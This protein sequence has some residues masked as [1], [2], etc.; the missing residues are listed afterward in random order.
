MHHLELRPRDDIDNR[1]GRCKKYYE[2]DRKSETCNLQIKRAPHLQHR[3]ILPTSEAARKFRQLRSAGARRFVERLNR[4]GFS[5]ARNA[6]TVKN[7]ARRVGTIQRV[8]VNTRNIVIQKVMTL[9]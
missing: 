6:E 1:K 9:F 2:C 4:R 5:S 8:E 3:E 7:Y